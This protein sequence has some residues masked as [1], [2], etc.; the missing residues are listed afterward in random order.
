MKTYA[1]LRIAWERPPAKAGAGFEES[2]AGTQHNWGIAP[3]GAS[4]DKTRLTE[5]MNPD[6]RHGAKLTARLARP[7]ER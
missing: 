2:R 5:T 3:H 1:M 6:T 4:S 7:R